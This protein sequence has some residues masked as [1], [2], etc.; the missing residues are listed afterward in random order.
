MKHILIVFLFMVLGLI[1]I[2]AYP[3]PPPAPTSQ[4]THALAKAPPAPTPPENR[5]PTPEQ[6][7]ARKKAAD[8]WPSEFCEIWGD[9]LR[10]M[11]PGSD[12]H[13]EQAMMQRAVSEHE[14]KPDFSE[15]IRNHRPRMGMG[16][17]ELI[18]AVGKPQRIHR[19]VTASGTRLQVVSPRGHYY[20]L[21]GNVLT[22][23]QD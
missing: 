10:E 21:E 7:A 15:D 16:L 4:L 3:P 2:K 14:A 8:I 17:C 1:L 9:R 19:T 23:W 18:A 12:E 22:A 20:Y 11:K 5:Q 13:F 6:N